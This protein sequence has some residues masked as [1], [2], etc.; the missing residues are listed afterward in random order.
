MKYPHLL[1]LVLLLTAGHRSSAAGY[2][3]F[4]RSAAGLGRAFSAEAA[5]GDDATVIASNP[6]GMTL[7]EDEWSLAI[8]ASGIFPEVEVSGVYA[9]P[10]TPAGFVV[11]AQGG[12]VADDAYL[13]YAYVAKKINEQL[14]FGFGAFS[15]FGLKTNYPVN[16]TGRAIA[17]FSELVTLNLNPSL[18]WKINEQWAL[19]A[20]FDALYADGKLTSSN[21]ATL[22]VLDLAGDDWGYGFNAGVLFSP[23]ES[24]RFG[25]HYRSSID[26]NLE[27]PTVSIVPAFNGPTTL[28]VE[29]PDNV[30]FSAVH[31]FNASWSI[32]GDVMWTNWS[33]FQQLAPFITGAPAQPPVQPENWKDSW[34]FALGTTWRASGTW[35]FRAGMAYDQTPVSEVDLTLRIP[36]ADRFWLTAGFTW[37]FAPC[38]NLD[39][40]YAHIFADDVFI[41]EGSAATG[42]FRGQATGSADVVSLGLST[43]F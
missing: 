37:E 29:L 38:W 11:P 34:R 21:A 43:E 6:A 22:P 3:L 15:S 26:L 2:Q 31:D 40:G 4:E 19:G 17:D 10:G 23:A 5:M 12:N 28:A 20:G 25:L 35:T 16:F 1:P 41:S 8:G 24:T 18:A 7:L 33:K 13:P 30:E 9:P 39:L 14:V 36:D 42:F 27:G 32:H